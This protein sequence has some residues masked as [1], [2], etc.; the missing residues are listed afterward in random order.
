M[1][2]RNQRDLDDLLSA[3]SG[4]LG[5]LYQRLSKAQ[6][7]RRLDR[8]IL[9]EAS[10]AVHGR[11]KSARW[12]VGFG[13]AA[14]VLLAA[15]IAWRVNSDL[16]QQRDS[17]TPA[18]PIVVP[19]DAPAPMPLDKV[20]TVQTHE[21]APSRAAA[22]ASI[23]AQGFDDVAVGEPV[24]APAKSAAMPSK[25]EAKAA[26]QSSATRNAELANKRSQS[27]RMQAAEVAATKEAEAFPA[28]A[29]APPSA[30]L[31][32]PAV[33]ADMAASQSDAAAPAATMSQRTAADPVGES[34]DGA[35]NDG[36][37][38]RERSERA[39]AKSMTA[40]AAI[41]QIRSLLTQDR[42]A[43]AIQRL[44]DLRRQHPDLVIPDDLRALER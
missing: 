36:A 25:S 5:A 41:A 16:V 14:G 40:E 34:V 20:I 44:A 11:P 17:A 31:A 13:T 33:A 27:V 32:P 29:A 3:N 4:E 35:A 30:A 38:I 22:R 10:R 18:A 21:L 15:G 2:T 6:P 12:L 42:R 1:T 19:A 43:E 39:K 24:S 8:Q 23:S 37:T 7:P 26:P 28:P 9:A